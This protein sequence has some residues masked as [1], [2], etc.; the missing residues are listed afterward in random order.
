MLQD[1]DTVERLRLATL[2]DFG[3]LDEPE[4]AILDRITTLAARLFD[5]PM[6]LV[7]LL[8]DSRQVL[9]SRFG[10]DVTETSRD[11]AFC[12]HTIRGD[13]VMI[14]HDALEDPRFRTNALVLG[15]PHIRFYAGAPLRSE[16]GVKLGAMCVLDTVPRTIDRTQIELLGELAELVMEHF[17]LRRQNREATAALRKYDAVIQASPSG[18]VTALAD[19]TITSW[20][21]AAQRIVGWTREDTIGRVSPL[22][23]VSADAERR[24]FAEQVGRGEFVRNRHLRLTHKAGHSVDVEV[25]GGPVRDALGRVVEGVYLID[26]VTSELRENAV[27]R[28]RYEILELVANDA[29]LDNLLVRLVENVELA[30][31]HSVSAIMLVKN[32]SLHHGAFGV[33]LSPEYLAAIDGLPI[34]PAVGSCGAAAY[35]GETVIAADIETHP[36]WENYRELATRFGLAAC[37][38]VPIRTVTSGIIG[39]IASYATS[40]RTPTEAELRALAEAAH[41]AAIAIE[42]HDA[43][44]K[45]EEMALHDAL[46]GLPNRTLFEER[47]R[48]AIS[49]AKRSRKR[50]AVGMLDLDRFKVIND[51]LGHSVGDLLLVEVAKR[52]RRSVRAQD[53]VARMGGDEFLILLADLDD[54]RETGS[55]IASRTLASLEERF[56][57]GGNELFVRGSLGVA[58][59]PDDAIEPS[60]LMRLADHAM[61]EAKTSGGGA[62]FHDA[63]RATDG[64]TR[65]A[66]ETYLNQALGKDE[67]ELVYQ[68]LVACRG[69]ETFG[70]E[71]LLRW[72]HPVLGV[73][74]PDRF[75]PLAEETGLIISIG[76]WVLREACRFSRRWS[77]AGGLGVVTVNVS[78][79][80]FEDRAFIGTVVAALRDH[81]VP[82]A[83]L[84]LEIT[85]T[86]IMRSPAQTA[87]T[88]AELRALGVRTVIDDFGSGYSSLNYLKRFPISML[89]IDRTFVSEIGSSTDSTSDEAIVRAIVAVGGAL[90]LT[91]VAEGVETPAQHAFLCEVGCDYVQGYL[92]A[93]PMSGERLLAWRQN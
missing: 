8:D 34:G 40:P 9:K 2:H 75:V 41:V 78:P 45:L 48:T 52:L 58:V 80:Q 5:M 85:E 47:L 13:D 30:I 84:C 77:A 31:P 33:A 10:L 18:I 12:D 50:V 6:A 54:D 67:F 11:V 73:L 36:N 62:A 22:D 17:K 3:V 83:N 25:S 24:N 49:I 7:T 66:L 51:S 63:S 70:A 61:Y 23:R 86:I 57:P 32:G 68:P 44:I 90:G 38:S 42:S 20:N 64:L 71:A 81:G 1:R 79:R 69:G 46:T 76:A 56:A 43:R 29:P 91:V 60:Q 16:S 92:H 82:P 88:L 26:D 53:T 74:T 37:W 65:L 87:A 28:N 15:D 4:E 27:E 89:K 59:Y 35:L 72:R 14:V 39:T 93:R 19:G 21:D 55:E